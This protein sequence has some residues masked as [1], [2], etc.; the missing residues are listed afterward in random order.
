MGSLEWNFIGSK[1]I[2]RYP[3]GQTVAVV[4]YESRISS[5]AKT[6][7]PCRRLTCRVFDN[8]KPSLKKSQED[9]LTG[10]ETVFQD[11]PSSSPDLFTSVDPEWSVEIGGFTLNYDSSAHAVPSVKNF[12]L[13]N[14]YMDKVFL[15]NKSASNNFIVKSKLSPLISFAL[16][17]SSVHRKLCTQ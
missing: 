11:L 8:E 15:F 16:A 2:L 9:C 4:E 7:G 17:V 12:Q 5:F 13:Q 1:F 14:M 10:Q 3:S 6:L